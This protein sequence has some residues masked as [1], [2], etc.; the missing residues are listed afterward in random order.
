MVKMVKGELE[1][2]VLDFLYRAF[3]GL[4][5]YSKIQLESSWVSIEQR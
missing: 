1:L 5:E 3:S 4:L 2:P